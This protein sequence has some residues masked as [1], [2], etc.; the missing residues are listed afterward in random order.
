MKNILCGCTQLPKDKETHSTN[1]M[2][3]LVMGGCYDK[4]QPQWDVWG[5]QF[6]IIW[7]GNKTDHDLIWPLDNKF[8][9]TTNQKHAD[10]MEGRLL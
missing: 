8:D 5:G 6:H 7:D 10:T 3:V 1:Q 4:M 2:T 9:T